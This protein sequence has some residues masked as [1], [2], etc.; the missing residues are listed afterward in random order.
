MSV[1]SPSPVQASPSKKP[2]LSGTPAQPGHGPVGESNPVARYVPP[3]WR[4]AGSPVNH[5]PRV[6]GQA[7]A[8]RRPIGT[9]ATAPI[10]PLSTGQ[11][12]F[13][14]EGMKVLTNGSKHHGTFGALA[15]GTQGFIG[16][17]TEINLDG[18]RYTGTIVERGN[19]QRVFVRNPAVINAA[20]VLLAMG[21][22]R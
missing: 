18:T 20:H 2:R 10:R 13:V 6:E 1:K 12:R 7:E 11:S 16:H 21:S 22:G 5:A 15:D 14:G 19:G 4:V 17:V 3:R 8:Q 9:T